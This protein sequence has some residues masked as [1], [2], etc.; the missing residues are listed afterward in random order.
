DEGD[1]NRVRFGG[2]GSVGIDTASRTFGFALGLPGADE[3]II[4]AEGNAASGLM[5]NGV[6]GGDADG[7]LLP[8]AEEE[9]IEWQ[10]FWIQIVPDANDPSTHKATVFHNGSL[11]GLEFPIFPGD[12]N[13]GGAPEPSLYFG[14]AA[15]DHTGA[16]DFDFLHVM[17]G[18]VDPVPAIGSDPN[19][20]V[21]T[22]SRLGQV[23]TVPSTHE[24]AI[25]IRNNGE[26][27]TLN[28]SNYELTGPDADHWTLTNSPAT[29]APDA[30][31]E[32][33]YTFNTLGE[34]GAFV[35]TLVLTSD[36]PDT[37]MKEIALSASVINQAGPGGHYP[38][39][40]AAGAVEIFDITGY[41]RHG[42]AD[43]S[44][45]TVTFGEG[46]LA[47]T[48]TAAKVSAG[49]TLA[50]PNKDLSTD[51]VSISMWVRLDALPGDLSSILG[52]GADP[53]PDYALLTANGALFWLVPAAGGDPVIVTDPVLSAGQAHHIVAVSEARG[54]KVTLYVDGTEVGSTTGAVFA[55][56]GGTYDFGS[57]KT[58]LALNDATFD[59]LQVYTRAI[60]A[61]D[62]AILMAD[63]NGVLQP[64]G[65]VDSDNDG[66]SDAE[67]AGL[68]TDPL[69][70]DSDGDGLTDAEEVRT[71]NTDPLNEDTDGDMRTDA[72][73]IA[74]GFDP[75]DPNSPPPP[76][77]GGSISDGL[78]AY[79]PLDEDG[80]TVAADAFGSNDG[81]VMGTAEWKP[82][83]GAVGGA[84]FFDGSDG[85]IEVPDAPDFR[86]AENESWTASLWYKTDAVE[87]DQGLITK[88]YADDS[89][90]TTGYWMLQTRAGGFTLDSR[91]CDG[92]N[93]R[94]R[95]D[96][97]S[98][99]SHGDGEWHHFVVARDS[100]SAEIRLY[101][102]GVVTTVDI[103]G[104]DTGQWAMG[105]NDDP[106]VIANH[107]NRFTAGWFD[108]IAIWKGR[109][110]TESEVAT[111]AA[112]GVGAALSDGGGEPFELTVE[113]T[114][115][116]GDEP[117]IIEFAN[118]D[119]DAL[120]FSDRTHEHNSA[121]FDSG[122]GKLSVGGDLVV[123]LPDYLVGQSY[124]RFA[125]N[126][127]DQGD[128][129]AT[130]TADAPAKWYLLLDN[131]IDGPGGNAGSS[132][133]SDPVLGGTFQW[134]IDGGWERVNTGI[135]PDGQA[136]Y[137]GVDEGG[138]GGLNQFYAVYTLA[139]PS[140]SVTVSNNGTGGSNM[141]SLVAGVADGDSGLEGLL[142]YW[143]FEEGT[144]AVAGDSSG[145]GNDGAIVEPDGA[146][147]N[148]PIL[149]SVY[150]S[151]DTSMIDFGNILP[152]IGVDADF[153]WSFWVNATETDNNDIVFGN[154]YAADGNDFAP[155][156]FVK[157]TPRVFEWHFDGGG[158]NIAGAEQLLPVGEWV[159]NVVVKSGTSLT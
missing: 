78:V 105:E 100:T 62:V 101:V 22:K 71:Y 54:N 59:H 133:D 98:G 67:E 124:V 1:G 2:K 46:A 136:D 80:G 91:C 112:G 18:A 152:E 96:S 38:L 110:L 120:T 94:A 45:G 74:G 82:G 72:A 68:G 33:T 40:E 36:D 129:S 125:N 150:S 104:A 49:G 115:L 111:I 47:G 56:T 107:F 3:A 50:V 31:E 109:A 119:E 84:I 64:E 16:Y 65:A 154:R 146:W 23:P 76:T 127:R 141:I 70:A 147:A 6:D 102:D 20:I 134:V 30:L 61:A 106:L 4:D 99:I 140:T 75:N 27:N 103:S 118:F 153:T 81:A 135:S 89:R 15:T 156:E 11:E 138:D 113:E 25:N 116:G 51:D 69:D 158:E 42:L 159:H 88:G 126:A 21:S 7:N 83:E 48:G 63:P 123:P 90:A 87:N 137:T 130:V 52:V 26:T 128:Y 43:T 157:F 12:G 97:D 10:E 60:S 131:R 55:P 35:A 143:R 19:I 66:L 32:I 17:A 142:G 34:T 58:A 114:G 28:V 41:D 44:V 155:R 24:G 85:F 93:P 73:E 151:T 149:G 9:L 145:N 53:N 86:F 57:Y 79:W 39:D 144:G 122:T 121:A 139:E 37:P 29:L 95:I 92:G 8:I 14:H 117:A 132:N 5:L 148:D 77:Q 108:D 13:V